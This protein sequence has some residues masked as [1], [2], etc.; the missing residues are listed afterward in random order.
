MDYAETVWTTLCTKDYIRKTDA[1]MMRIS[2]ELF[3]TSTGVK[4]ILEIS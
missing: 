4:Y 2:D 3:T 1:R